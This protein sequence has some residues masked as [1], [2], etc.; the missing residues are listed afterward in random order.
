MGAKDQINKFHS[1]LTIIG[2]FLES[3]S[4]GRCLQAFMQA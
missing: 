1:L 2:L 4:L 3:L